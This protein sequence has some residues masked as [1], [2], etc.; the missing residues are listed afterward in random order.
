[1]FRGAG[2]KFPCQEIY[3]VLRADAKTRTRRFAEVLARSTAC[4]LRM[5]IAYL[6][7]RSNP[8]YQSPL[9][10]EDLHA[11]RHPN[12]AIQVNIGCE[13]NNPVCR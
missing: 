9:C 5:D 12:S 8:T 2:V 3:T 6:L 10:T 7:N 11:S 13:K 1:M 4:L